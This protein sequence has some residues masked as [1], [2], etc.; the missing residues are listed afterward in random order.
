M[1]PEGGLRLQEYGTLLGTQSTL[2]EAQ[3]AS[4]CLSCM[5]CHV[6][7]VFRQPPSPLIRLPSRHTQT[8]PRMHACPSEPF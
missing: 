6:P 5:Q 8:H 2:F 4:L 7:F 3:V 1:C